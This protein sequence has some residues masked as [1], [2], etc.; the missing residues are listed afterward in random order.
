MC[1]CL[2]CTV[3]PCTPAGHEIF[4]FA[5][6]AL[7]LASGTPSR[8]PVACS[9]CQH[10]YLTCCCC[11]LASSCF[12]Y[13]RYHGVDAA[14]SVIAKNRVTFEPASKRD[15]RWATFSH[16]DLSDRS[17][18]IAS[19]DLRSSSKAVHPSSYDV[20]LSRCAQKWQTGDGIMTSV[21]SFFSLL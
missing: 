7:C 17:A 16:L 9:P 5:C 21:V 13:C 18:S 3:V 12:A 15:S 1:C 4:S 6:I 14:Q 11:C 20:I 8:L 2:H 19:S 10:S